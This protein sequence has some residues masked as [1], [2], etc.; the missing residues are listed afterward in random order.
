MNYIAITFLPSRS[1]QKRLNA[2][3]QTEHLANPKSLTQAKQFACSP[4]E[5]K[6]PPEKVVFLISTNTQTHFGTNVVRIGPTCTRALNYWMTT[7]N[8]GK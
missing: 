4:T 7:K 6:K 1:T 5:I 3:E 2:I 8:T